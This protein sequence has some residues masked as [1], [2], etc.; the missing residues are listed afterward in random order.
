MTELATLLPKARAL[1]E[2]WRT[3]GVILGTRR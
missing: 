1:L 2:G 3:R